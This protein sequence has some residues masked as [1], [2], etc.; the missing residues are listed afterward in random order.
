M[1]MYHSYQYSISY[2]TGGIRSVTCVS[3]CVFVCV[4]VC[5]CVCNLNIAFY[6]A[7]NI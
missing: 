6:L 7:Y 1:N 3:V 2:S 5:V 4:C